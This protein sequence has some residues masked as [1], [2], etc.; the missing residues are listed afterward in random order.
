ML[1]PTPGRLGPFCVLAAFA[2]FA[3]LASGTCTNITNP[4]PRS[5]STSGW[6]TL[7]TRDAVV[8]D[9]LVC[10]SDSP[11]TYNITV[12]RERHVSVADP[13]E[14]AALYGLAERYLCWEAGFRPRCPGLPSVVSLAQKP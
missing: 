2:S 12:P 6:S 8:V 4:G 5:Y 11:K 10:A 1:P 3:S 14:E 7:N 13:A 9:Q